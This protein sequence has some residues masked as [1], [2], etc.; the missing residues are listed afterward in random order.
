MSWNGFFSEER[1]IT[2][3]AC[4]HRASV[5]FP[6]LRCKTVSICNHCEHP[7]VPDRELSKK[8]QLGFAHLCSRKCW[9]E[10]FSGHIAEEKEARRKLLL[11]FHGDETLAERFIEETCHERYDSWQKGD[12]WRDADGID[13]MYEHFG[14]K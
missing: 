13:F 2:Y 6:C 14:P 11:V 8:Y 10:Y 9:E 12:P 3:S 5:T 1:P 4:G 7:E